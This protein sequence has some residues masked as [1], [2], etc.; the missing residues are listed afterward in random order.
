MAKVRA[1]NGSKR[2]SDPHL[3][4]L[5][6]SLR[7]YRAI[8][9]RAEQ[10]VAE[11]DVSQASIL[12]ETHD[13]RGPITGTL[14]LG[15]VVSLKEHFESLREADF[16]FY[17]E[18]DRRYSEVNVE[19]EK[20]LK[21]KETADLAA[22]SLAREIQ[23]YKDEKANNLREQITGERGTY[24]TKEDTKNLEEKFTTQFKPIADWVQGQLGGGLVRAESRAE[25]HWTD[26][27]RSQ[28]SEWRTGLFIGGGLAFG[29]LV[30]GVATFVSGH[31][32]FK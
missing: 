6:E 13:R 11:L 29:G 28:R 23:D 3:T 30:L 1:R 24:A 5:E 22:L 32:I 2:S 8:S 18:R 27:Q 25:A 15:A 9:A 31:V 12:H 20:A 16:R 10:Q 17:E 19:R 14:T 21:I 7:R 26:N 4:G